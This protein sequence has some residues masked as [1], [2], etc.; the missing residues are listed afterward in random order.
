MERDGEERVN[1]W[2]SQE[3]L[4]TEGKGKGKDKE[5]NEQGRDGAASTM[6]LYSV[7]TGRESF[8]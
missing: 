4:Q 1:R 8:K 5:K 2:A 7:P 6:P 3:E